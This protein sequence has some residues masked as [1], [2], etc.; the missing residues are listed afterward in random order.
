MKQLK[1]LNQLNNKQWQRQQQL[2]QKH[3]VNL[4]S[5][6]RVYTVR[7]RHLSLRI[8]SFIRKVIKNKEDK[9]KGNHMGS[10]KIIQLLHNSHS[11]LTLVVRTHYQT[12]P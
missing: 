9:K 1:H 2:Q 5:Q 7:P 10:P 4:K 12:N 3:T 11:L 8:V 6:D